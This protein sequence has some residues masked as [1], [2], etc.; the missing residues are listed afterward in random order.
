MDGNTEVFGLYLEEIAFNHRLGR[1]IN[2]TGSLACSKTGLYVVK[3]LISG[4]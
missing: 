4:D 3:I 2:S 1:D